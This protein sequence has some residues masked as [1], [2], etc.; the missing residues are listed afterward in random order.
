MFMGVGKGGQEGYAPLLDFYTLSLQISKIL[1][2]LV[3]NIGSILIAPAPEK[4]SADA[5]GHVVTS[6]D[7]TL[8][9]DY[10]C[11]VASNKQ[12]NHWTEIRRT[13]QEHQRALETHKQVQIPS[14]SS[15]K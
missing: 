1:P 4:F 9:N 15:M 11:L 6:L 2:F 13:Q 7:K 5:L 14:A 8:Y 10:L 12:Q 3:V